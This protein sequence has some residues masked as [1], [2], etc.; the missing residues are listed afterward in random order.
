MANEISLSVNFAAVNA[1]SGAAVSCTTVASVT[2]VGVEMN[3][4][5]LLVGTS[6]LAMPV[7]SVAVAGL[8]VI[9]NLTPITT[10]T[11]LYVGATGVSAANA[12]FQIGS[13]EAAVFRRGPNALF[14]L[15]TVALPTGILVQVTTVSN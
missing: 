12:Y 9:K 15:S 8:T 6:Q 7:G 5:T 13:G 2:M 11:T 1:T 14:L 10:A 4:E 3:N